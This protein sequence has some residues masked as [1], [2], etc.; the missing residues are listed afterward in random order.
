MPVGQD[1]TFLHVTSGRLQLANYLLVNRSNG[2]ISEA[3]YL[4]E[5][6]YFFNVDT[7]FFLDVMP[8]QRGVKCE[9]VGRSNV[10][11]RSRGTRG[12]HREEECT[13]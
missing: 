11:R 10:N 9:K 12:M 3:R 5:N 8:F 4:R 1:I 6:V 13:L 7:S 2:S